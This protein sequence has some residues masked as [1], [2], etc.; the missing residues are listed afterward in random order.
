MASSQVIG[1]WKVGVTVASE[2]KVVGST[3]AIWYLRDAVTCNSEEHALH[4]A[5]S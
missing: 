2:A 1:L 5:I 3:V 4:Y